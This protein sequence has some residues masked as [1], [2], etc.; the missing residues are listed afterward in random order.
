[1][2]ANKGF[3]TTRINVPQQSLST[4]ILKLKISG[5][6]GKI[7]VLENKIKWSNTFPIK[8][9]DI[10]NYR[11]LEQ[12]VEQIQRLQSQQVKLQIIP[13]EN[14]GESDINIYC[15][16]KNRGML[17]F[18]DSGDENTGRYQSALNLTVEK[19]VEP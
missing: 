9:G 13:S 19:S 10:L 12:G 15:T 7:N 4:G 11:N 2:L 14:S 5:Y 17:I 8:S 1:M 3:A 6:I 16:R 18:D